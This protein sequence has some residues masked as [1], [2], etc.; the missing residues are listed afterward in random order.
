MQCDR[1]VRKTPVVVTHS[2][3]TSRLGQRIGSRPLLQLLHIL[4]V[5]VAGRTRALAGP[6]LDRNALTLTRR[7]D[8]FLVRT[9]SDL[10]M[11]PTVSFCCPLT[12]APKS[13]LSKH[14][15]L[16]CSSCRIQ[17]R[18]FEDG[19]DTVA[20]L[21]FLGCQLLCVRHEKRYAFT[22][23]YQARDTLAAYG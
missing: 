2:T 15:P 17:H 23:S 18:N 7:S 22:A 4:L 10:S 8:P 11:E 13:T 1:L 21:R 14:V 6:S 20:Y 16:V 19:Q 12:C 3:M 9:T 5:V